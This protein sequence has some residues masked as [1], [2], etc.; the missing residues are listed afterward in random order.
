MHATPVT[1]APIAKVVE[2]MPRRL[3]V[4]IGD[5]WHTV[6][7]ADLEATPIRVRVDGE[8]VEV[9]VGEPVALDPVVASAGPESAQASGTMAPLPTAPSAVKV[10]HCPMPGVII[11]VAVKVGDQVVTGDEICVL[12]AMKMRQI[13]RADWSGIVRAVHVSPGQQML[14]G[15]TILELE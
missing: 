10:F 7:V 11:S 8:P 15:E 2:S 3:R 14:D 5:S 9:D 12:E 1:R 4:R 6:E 13:L